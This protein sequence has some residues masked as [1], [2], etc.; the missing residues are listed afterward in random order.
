MRATL[1]GVQVGGKKE[2]GLFVG[3]SDSPP[4]LRQR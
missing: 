2:K 4:S 1:V 3:G